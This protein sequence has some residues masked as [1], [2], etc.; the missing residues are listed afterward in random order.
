MIFTRAVDIHRHIHCIQINLLATH[1]GLARLDQVIFQI[2][3]A[4]IPSVVWAGQIGAVGVPVQQVKRWWRFT[5]EVVADDVVPNEVIGAQKAERA[6]EVLTLHESALAHLF[7]AVLDKRIVNKDVQNAGVGKV[8]QAGQE[9]GA[10]NGF[11]ATRGQHGQ[12]G[13]QHGSTDAKAQCI[14]GW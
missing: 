13:A 5:F 3:I 2:G 12:R 4:Q 9:R 11:L 7:L 10:G 6:G 1:C 14:D 8:Q